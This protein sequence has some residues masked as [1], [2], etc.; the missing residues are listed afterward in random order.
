[1]SVVDKGGRGRGLKLVMRLCRTFRTVVVH[2]ETARLAL[3]PCGTTLGLE[4]I[5]ELRGL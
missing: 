1:M 2:R 5:V 3:V 4:T